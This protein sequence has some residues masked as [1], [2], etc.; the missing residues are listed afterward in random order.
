MFRQSRQVQP[1]QSTVWSELARVGL[2]VTLEK[3]L[4]A[5]IL[6]YALAIGLFSLV[7]PLVVQELTN[8]FVFSIQPIMIATLALIVLFGLLFIGFFRVFQTSAT[9]TLFQRLYARIAIAMTEHLPRVRED[10]FLPSYANY[11]GEAELLPRAVVVVLVDLINL[12]VSGTAG[13]CMLIVYHPYFLLY[14]GFLLGGFALVL[15]TTGQGGIRA[16]HAVSQAHYDL[17]TWIQ[18]VAQNRLHFKATS[19][20]ALLLKKT[21]HLAEQY[22]AARRSR[23]GILTWRQYVSTVMWEAVC[24]SGMIALGGW[25][26]SNGHITLGQFVA[27]E[28]IVGTL[29]LNLDTVTRR[30]YAVTYILT[31]LDELSRVFSLPKDDLVRQVGLLSPRSRAAGLHVTCKGVTARVGS[32]DALVESFDLEVAPGEKI[33]IISSRS[34]SKSVLA[35]LLAGLARPQE[36]V[37]RYNEIDLR[38]LTMEEVNADRGLVL[39]SLLTLFGGSIEENITLR[40]PEI[41]FEDLRWALRLTELDDEIDALPQGLDTPVVA[42]GKLFT[43]SQILRMLVARAVVTR[44]PLLVFDGTLHNMEPALRQVLLRRLCNKEEGWTAI[45]VTNDPAIGDYVDRRIVLD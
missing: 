18:E 41:G 20:A 24:H 2:I 12:I 31:S 33:G 6:S 5:I 42:G 4:L 15:V 7:I 23:S 16:T 21:D 17:M 35:M 3:R 11:F 40:R 8:T 22:L 1:I 29:L 37:V 38:E 10:V 13:L 14:D 28:V 44:P 30:M 34:T 45:F 26:L 32:G 27:A 25:L 39:D 36:G 19:S 9:E 43:K